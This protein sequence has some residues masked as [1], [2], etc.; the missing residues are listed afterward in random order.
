MTSVRST[1]RS[2]AASAV[3]VDSSPETSRR[4][5]RLAGVSATVAGS[6]YVLVGLFHPANV[7]GAVDSTSWAI[8][9]ALA[10]AMCF[11]GLL[12][13]AGLHARQASS[14]GLMGLIGHVLL[15]LWLVLIMGF[16]F[17]ETLVLPLESTNAAFV[18]S[19]MGMLT[20]GDN[21]VD[22][23]ALPTVWLLT[24]PAYL[25]G[26]LLFGVATFR[27]GILSRAAGLLLAVGT[28]LAPAAALLP[29]AA[30]P[31]IAI[32]VGIALAWL[33][34]SLWTEQRTRS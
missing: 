27:A 29:N 7:P 26:G 30:Q 21:S 19:W 18:E 2:V 14:T 5:L 1:P 34:Y 24:L 8:V 31:K 13:M 12:G 9:H 17:V 33:G 16:S 25:L 28:L 6:C 22:L 10:C 23:G 4:L 11:F 20:G 15:S 3:P 32:P